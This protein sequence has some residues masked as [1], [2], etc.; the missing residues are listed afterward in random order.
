MISSTLG[1]LGGMGPKATAVFIER[2]VEH[3]AAKQDQD[4]INMVVLNHAAL[5]DRTE[6]IE[7][8]NY[9]NFT[10]AIHRDLKLL[11]QAGAANIAVPC[12]TSHFFYGQMQQ[13]TSVPIIHMVDETIRTVRE[14]DS[15]I[16]RIGLLAT[17]GTVKSGVY[18]NSCVEYGLDLVVPPNQLQREISEI[19][20]EQVKRNG[21]LNAA[22]LVHIID[23]LITDYRCDRV[24]IACTELSCIPLPA[25]Q[26]QHVVDAMEVLVKQSILRSGGILKAI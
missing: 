11:E 25:E 7:S 14:T 18:A 24:I 20:Y 19:I 26:G 23:Q 16:E 10:D 9:D 12:N 1:V 22:G 13:M 6:A 21:D 5:P 17:N 3:T 4:H 2:I 15:S 8:G